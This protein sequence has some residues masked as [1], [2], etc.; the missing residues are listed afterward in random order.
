MDEKT[1]ANGNVEEESVVPSATIPVDV[2]EFYNE[3]RQKL[4]AAHPTRFSK[5]CAEAV[6]PVDAESNEPI[7]ADFLPKVVAARASISTNDTQSKSRGMSTVDNTA[8]GSS[9]Y[10]NNVKDHGGVAIKEET[11]AATDVTIAVTSLQKRPSLTAPAL[12]REDEQIMRPGAFARAPGRT[13][14]RNQAVHTV[15][16]G[17]RSPPP[18]SSL[19]RN[20]LATSPEDAD[21][22]QALTLAMDGSGK[23]LARAWEMSERNASDYFETANPVDLQSEL[24]RR[25]EIKRNQRFRLLTTLT[26]CG[27]L[28][29]AL[30]ALVLGLV[31]GL[32]KNKHKWDDRSAGPVLNLSITQAPAPFQIEGLPEYSLEILM[33]DTDGTSPQTQAYQWMINDPFLEEY[34]AP[35]QLQRFALAVIYFSTHGNTWIS[36]GNSYLAAANSDTISSPASSG[37]RTSS[38]PGPPGLPEPPPV[39]P[40]LVLQ[41]LTVTTG[42]ITKNVSPWL[43]YTTDECLWFNKN[44]LSNAETCNRDGIY[45]FLFLSNNNLQGTLPPEMALLTN[46]HVVKI[47]RNR[48]EGT[49]PSSI[50]KGWK[51]SILALDVAANTMTGTVSPAIAEWSNTLR[52]IHLLGNR[53]SGQLFAT[54]PS[55]TT[56]KTGVLGLS[57]LRILMAGDN[58]FTGSIPSQIS[59][60]LPYLKTMELSHNQL[61]SYIPSEIGVLEEI[62]VLGLANNDF[63][64]RIPS[65]LGLLSRVFSMKFQNNFLSGSLPSELGQLSAM[66]ILQLQNNVE[67]HGIIPSEIGALAVPDADNRSFEVPAIM[68]VDPSQNIAVISNS[69]NVIPSLPATNE[70]STA[71][72]NT[73]V[74]LKVF[75]LE[76]THLTGELP[77]EFCS[78]AVEVLGFDC[79]KELCGCDCPCA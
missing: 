17:E 6:S 37:A 31:V 47:G 65:Q 39:I 35:R 49:L 59:T 60:A 48:L 58:A 3:I 34:P 77:S 23:S 73:M 56:A 67:L 24:N 36:G 16:V 55:V 50:F 52:A 5:A 51:D 53:F 70:V 2:T 40:G 32:S 45:T 64:G 44:S 7:D 8:E 74:Y 25:I 76:G 22:E 62:R 4:D 46:L 66:E 61:E 19:T 75:T 30:V 18:P 78:S 13:V 42:N 54:D 63:I 1:L 33:A 43:D 15:S 72:L 26:V 41:K 9:Q 68:N 69:S 21:P 20:P 57:Q 28:S 79:S 27:C 11:N 10:R 12:V 38:L 14:L 71:D 29:T